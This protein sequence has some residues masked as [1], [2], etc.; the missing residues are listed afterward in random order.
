M[1]FLTLVWSIFHT[2]KCSGIVSYGMFLLTLISYSC[3]SWTYIFLK[4]C[5]LKCHDH[6]L[7][8]YV[9][10][11]MSSSLNEVM[12]DTVTSSFKHDTILFEQKTTKPMLSPVVTF[13]LLACPLCLIGS[14][15]FPGGFS[16]A[17]V[18]KHIAGFIPQHTASISGSL[19]C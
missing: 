9:L 13:C 5:F 14:L 12:E 7:L 15:N 16:E 18:T 10:Y 17:P 11:N 19:F 4:A 3:H 2:S 6:H 1:Y 8:N